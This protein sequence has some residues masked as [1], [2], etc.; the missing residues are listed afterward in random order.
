[1]SDGPRPLSFLRTAI[2]LALVFDMLAGIVL[3]RARPIAFTLFM[4][5][6]QPLLAVALV[7]LAGVVLTELRGKRTP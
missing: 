5:L 7:L 2:V 4:F 3:M 6:A 1:M